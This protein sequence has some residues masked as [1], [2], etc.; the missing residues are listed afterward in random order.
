M[1]PDGKYFDSVMRWPGRDLREERWKESSS[2]DSTFHEYPNQFIRL[3]IGS[4]EAI[5]RIQDFSGETYDAKFELA[6]LREHVEGEPVFCGDLT[7]T[8]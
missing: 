1:A 3:A 4:V 7:G 6:G 5:I 2:N 8:R